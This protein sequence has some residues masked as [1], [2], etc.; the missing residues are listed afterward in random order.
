MKEKTRNADDNGWSPDFEK[1][2]KPQKKA[3]Y[4]SM[5][6]LYETYIDDLAALSHDRVNF[7]DTSI[8]D[9]LPPRFAPCYNFLFAKKFFA[10]FVTATERIRNSEHPR[11]VAE[12]MAVKQIIEYSITMTEAQCSKSRKVVNSIIKGLRGFE[13]A[14]FEDE[15]FLFLW[16]G[17][18]DGIEYI[19]ELG[20]AN[21]ECSKWFKAFRKKQ[22]VNPFV[23]DDD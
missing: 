5:C 9:A 3:L 19:K 11:C 17:A 23:E 16:N 18:F 1:L 22:P 6:Y 2:T 20:M 4:T 8:A 15:D 13:E 7:E 10:C 12:E 14:I 21:L